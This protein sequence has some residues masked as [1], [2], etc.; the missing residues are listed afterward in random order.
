MQWFW[1]KQF[2]IYYLENHFRS[3][4]M[5]Y[6]NRMNASSHIGGVERCYRLKGGIIFTMHYGSIIPLLMRTFTFNQYLSIT[7]LYPKLENDRLKFTMNTEI[8]VTLQD[9]IGH[10]CMGVLHDIKTTKK[11][12]CK[13]PCQYKKGVIHGNGGYVQECMV[14]AGG[15]Q[16]ILLMKSILI[17]AA[18]A[19]YN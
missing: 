15:I 19:Y 14:Q 11:K 18:G 4:G 8:V 7:I 12:I 16:H 5:E 17:D 13:N 1:V 2:A 10:Y 9:I 6:I 3:I